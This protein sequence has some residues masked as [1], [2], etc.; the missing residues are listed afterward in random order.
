VLLDLIGSL[1]S[2]LSTYYFIRLN[3]K[4]WI[5]CLV[6]CCLNSLLYWRNGIYAGTVLESCYFFSTC[7]GW[8]L[9]RKP[10]KEKRS[11]IISLSG[12]QWFWAVF[13]LMGLWAIIV[14]L[15]ARFT[16]S[17]VAVLDALTTA[18]CLIAQWLMCHKAIAT[19]IFWFFSDCLYSYL[20]FQKQMP[21]HCLLMLCY[22]GMAV[23]GYLSWAKLSARNIPNLLNQVSQGS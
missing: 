3:S 16:H 6:S 1:T 2:M 11:S 13:F 21:F 12:Q 20:Y 7:Y 18:I 22:T 17:N 5:V 10:K 9:W 4:A 14:S 19:W 23:A 15:L 8:F